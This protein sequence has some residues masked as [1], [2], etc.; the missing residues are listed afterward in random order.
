MFSMFMMSEM[1]CNVRVV[2]HTHKKQNYHHIL[3][4]TSGL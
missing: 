3:Q 4:F 2:A 1:K